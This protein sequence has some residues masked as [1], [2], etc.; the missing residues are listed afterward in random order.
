MYT[1]P[2]HQV[3]CHPPHANPRQSLPIRSPHCDRQSNDA[4]AVRIKSGRGGGAASFRIRE[5][6]DSWGTESQ[7]G[8]K[9]GAAQ[10]GGGGRKATWRRL[11]APRPQEPLE[12]IP[13]DGCSAGV[14]PEA[15]ARARMWLE[16]N[17]SLGFPSL[18]LAPWPWDLLRIQIEGTWSIEGQDQYPRLSGRIGGS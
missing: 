9:H 11:S 16:Q 15:A 13:H 12:D 2:W 17:L 8:A 6:L 4:R 10:E 18:C 5:Q 3:V 14:L 1:Y 7:F